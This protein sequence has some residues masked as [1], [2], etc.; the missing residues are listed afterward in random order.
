[1]ADQYSPGGMKFMAGNRRT[2]DRLRNT[3]A[4]SR[5]SGRNSG[6]KRAVSNFGAKYNST[7]NRR[8]RTIKNLF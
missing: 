3:S 6:F 1:M 5:G 4:R 7:E 2:R 8:N